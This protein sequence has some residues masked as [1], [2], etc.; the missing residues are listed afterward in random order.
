MWESIG[1]V[2]ATVVLIAVYVVGLV[3]IPLGLGGTFIILGATVLYDWIHGFD[4]VGWVWLGIFAGLVVIGEILESIL[5]AAMAGRY[6]AGRWGIAGAFVG[7]IAGAT[8]GSGVVPIVG[9]LLGSFAGAFLG[10]F[11]LEWARRRRDTG[12]LG[13]SARAGWGAF[14]GKLGAVWI[15]LLIGATISGVSL[16]RI[17]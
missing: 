10:A 14:V 15:K 17:L 11:A 5:G 12:G 1:A 8:L 4:V 16:T 13:E 2:L 7:G 9:T 3:A 6:G